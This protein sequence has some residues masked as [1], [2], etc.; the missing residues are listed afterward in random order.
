MIEE[1]KKQLGLIADFQVKSPDGAPTG[2]SLFDD[3]LIWKGL[4]KGELSLLSGRLGSGA[5]SLW[6]TAAACAHRAGKWTAWI[7]SD[8]NLLPSALKQK[9]IDF[10]KF[11]VVNKPQELRKLFWLVQELVTSSLFELIACPAEGFKSHQ[12][13]KLKTL[14]RTHH[15][16]LV[17][18]L[19]SSEVTNRSQLRQNQLLLSD[20]IFSLVVECSRDFF[21][22][23]R[24]LHRPTPFFIQ[25]SQIY[26]DLMPRISNLTKPARIAA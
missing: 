3:F 15:V 24:A 22:I 17:M 6:L 2:I 11:L 13:K 7:N 12:L 8:S 5:S 1:L 26:A 10:S 21:V 14:A 25:G 18:I 16:A 4:P 23:K 9:E 20:S 19:T